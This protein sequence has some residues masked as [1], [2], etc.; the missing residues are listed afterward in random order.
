[1]GSWDR[2]R[3]VRGLFRA[4]FSPQRRRPMRRFGGGTFWGERRADASPLP[5]VSPGDR[6]LM[7]AEMGGRGL[8]AWSLV[9]VTQT[10][11]CS[12]SCDGKP[13]GSLKS[14]WHVLIY[15]LKLPHWTPECKLGAA[16]RLW[17]QWIWCLVGLVWGL[18]VQVEGVN[19]C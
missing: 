12:L 19:S 16:R 14:E 10:P 15:A 9:G 11:A 4:D 8:R 18:A 5:C 6:A 17:L 3:R 2:G 13:Q 7:R 1:M